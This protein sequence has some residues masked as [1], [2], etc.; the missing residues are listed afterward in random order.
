M[1]HNVIRRISFVVIFIMLL[2]TLGS[3]TVIASMPVE[4][5]P[6]KGTFNYTVSVAPWFI[7]NDE[8]HTYVDFYY[9]S[10]WEIAEPQFKQLAYDRLRVFSGLSQGVESV[11]YDNGPDNLNIYARVQYWWENTPNGGDYWGA[12]SDGVTPPFQ[13]Q[14]YCE[15]DVSS[16]ISRSN[17]AN[18]TLN[19]DWSLDFSQVVATFDQHPLGQ[20]VMQPAIITLSPESSNQPH[21]RVYVQVMNGVPVRIT[22]GNETSESPFPR[23]TYFNSTQWGFQ[24]SLDVLN[25]NV[26]QAKQ[27]LPS[28][29]ILSIFL[30]VAVPIAQYYAK[31]KKLRSEST[32]TL[33]M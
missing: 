10:N 18:G 30:A 9:G 19:L 33:A 7:M 14:N 21:L 17:V 16:L 4:S 28:L 24:D 2:V 27:S 6:L 23:F 13:V 12:G 32:Q 26:L 11:P 8:T 1:D 20:R 15:V 22:S 31:P 5:F 3:V 29:L 25:P